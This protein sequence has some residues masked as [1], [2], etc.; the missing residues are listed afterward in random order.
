MMSTM[1]FILGGCFVGAGL[2][3]IFRWL[4][5]KVSKQRWRVCEID[6]ITNAVNT[7]IGAHELLPPQSMLVSFRFNSHL[8]SV[9]I[10]YD[11]TLFSRFKQGLPCCLLVDK[12]NPQK[13]YNNAQLWQNY[14][15]FWLLS[16]ISLWMG[17]C[18]FDR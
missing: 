15:L 4:K 7:H 9:L 13:V 18:F 12:N 2:L 17:G 5:C 10:S 8:H 14:A 11:K 6:D 1:L 16:G 3:P